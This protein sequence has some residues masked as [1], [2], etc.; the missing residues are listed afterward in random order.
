MLSEFKITMIFC[1]TDDFLQRIC[2]TTEKML[3]STDKQYL[4]KHNV[5]AVFVHLFFFI[6][7]IA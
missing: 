1:M 6:G 3:E 4:I 2:I 5:L 7:K